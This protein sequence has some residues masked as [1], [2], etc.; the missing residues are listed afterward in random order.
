[1][2]SIV[3]TLFESHYHYG[4]A[5]L[6][7]SLYKN[8][9]TGNVFAGYRGSLPKWST[10]ATPATFEWQGAS[11]LKVADGL[12]LHFLPLETDYHFTNYKPDFM[13]QLWD[14]PAKDATGMFYFDPDIVIAA[15]W[16]FFEQ[17]I[18]CGIALCEDVNSPLQEFHPRRVFWR[19]YFEKSNLFLKFKNSIY[20]NGGL[21][22]ISKEDDDFLNLWVKV[23]EAMAPAIGG[24]QKS[25]L[26]GPK[27]SNEADGLFSPFNRTD[28]DALNATIEIFDANYSF[29]GKEGMGFKPGVC[30]VPHALGQPKPWNSNLI[31]EILMGRPPS[32]VDKFYWN[33]VV[34]KIKLRPAYLVSIR[35][36]GM[37]IA[38]IIGRI[39]KR[40]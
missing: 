23:Q 5:A 6:V 37:K 25:V 38:S 36:V 13:L 4:V 22:G 8:G 1:M 31:I 17:W 30:I 28:Q 26:S 34:G 9:F 40:I 18:G 24:L 14:G 16:K 32:I 21:I 20:V 15:P 35:K 27:V 10:K 29:I 33:N 11:T 7:N 3:C 2:N 12:M 19:K 39:Y